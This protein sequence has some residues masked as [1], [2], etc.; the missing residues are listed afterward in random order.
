VAKGNENLGVLGVQV[1]GNWGFK[2]KGKGMLCSCNEGRKEG[3]C[4]C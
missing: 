1:Q 4:C 3:V 2:Y